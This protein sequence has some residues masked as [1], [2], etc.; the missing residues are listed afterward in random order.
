MKNFVSKFKHVMLASPPLY[1]PPTVFYRTECQCM[2]QDHQITLEIEYDKVVNK[3]NMHLYFNTGYF[4]PYF[5][6]DSYGILTKIIGKL[7]NYIGRIKASIKLL[8][9]G[10][11][12]REDCFTF[13]DENHIKQFVE[14]VQEGVNFCK[15]E[16]NS[17]RRGTASR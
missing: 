7:K 12:V 1:D 14:A 16:G 17:G 5:Y 8:F 4:E 6:G 9:T 15:K 11:L 2:S 13:I 10:H 3:V